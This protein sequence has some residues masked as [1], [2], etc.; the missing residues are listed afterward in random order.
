MPKLNKRSEEN[1]FQYGSV[2]RYHNHLLRKQHQ[3]TLESQPGRR[4]KKHIRTEPSQE[5]NNISQDI[6]HIRKEL[7]LETEERI[8]R[9]RQRLT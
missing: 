5:L 3:L 2:E 7:S 6:K 4:T 9:K 1:P 8:E